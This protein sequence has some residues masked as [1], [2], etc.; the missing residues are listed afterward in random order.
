M[1]D[2]EETIEELEEQLE[3][4]GKDI[5]KIDNVGELVSWIGMILPTLVFIFFMASNLF[6]ISLY[7]GVAAALLLSGYAIYKLFH[8]PFDRQSYIYLCISG[9]V[10]AVVL[11]MLDRLAYSLEGMLAMFFLYQIAIAFVLLF[12]YHRKTN[13]GEIASALFF[14]G[15]L[16]FIFTFMTVTPQL[17]AII[18]LLTGAIFIIL[19]RQEVK[20]ISIGLILF[21]LIMPNFGDFIGSSI[22]ALTNTAAALAVVLWILSAKW[23]ALSIYNYF[24][25]EGE[26]KKER[27][28]SGATQFVDIVIAVGVL[29]LLIVSLPQVMNMGTFKY[30]NSLDTYRAQLASAE[31]I[32]E[33]QEAAAEFANQTVSGWKRF[34]TAIGCLMKGDLDCYEKALNP[35]IKIEGEVGLGQS[36]F[37]SFTPTTYQQD[38]FYKKDNILVSSDFRIVDLKRTIDEVKFECN[39]ESSDQKNKIKGVV[40]PPNYDIKIN[41]GDVE[42]TAVCRPEDYSGFTDGNYLAKLTATTSTIESTTKLTNLMMDKDS[43]I[44]QMNAFAKENSLSYT[45]STRNNILLGLYKTLISNVYPSG[46][47]ASQSE[48]GALLTLNARTTDDYVLGIGT[49]SNYLLFRAELKNTGKGTAE[50]SSVKIVLNKNIDANLCKTSYDVQGNIMT[51]IPNDKEKSIASDKQLTLPQCQLQINH[52]IVSDSPNYPKEISFDTTTTF[53]YILSNSITFK[54]ED[55]DKKI[56]EANKE[57]VEEQ[58]KDT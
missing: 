2:D 52:E 15:I 29:I 5:S 9:F 26:L 16:N 1:A 6:G 51:F 17:I 25:V 32:E 12:K 57:N 43:L 28:E 41:L 22:S 34:T 49:D 21:D 3:E 30:T 37:L 38:I 58:T 10:I 40:T 14:I 50:L 4:A 55:L 35:Q 48:E 46:K 33:S 44:T 18:N 8:A 31:R 20:A 36:V 7:F 23:L 56:A 54:F 42:G 19:G 45:T 13:I 47:V 53:N 11:I 27:I 39:I 24:A